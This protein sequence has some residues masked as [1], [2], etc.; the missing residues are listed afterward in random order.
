VNYLTQQ[1]T[2]NIFFDALMLGI[3][4]EVFLLELTSMQVINASQSDLAPQKRIS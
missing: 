4:D 2:N 1:S 3:Q